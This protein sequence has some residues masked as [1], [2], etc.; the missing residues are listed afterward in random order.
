MGE[1]GRGWAVAVCSFKPP[2]EANAYHSH[3]SVSVYRGCAL[4]FIHSFTALVFLCAYTHFVC[5]CLY[6]CMLGY[7]SLC[8][9]ICVLQTS[10]YIKD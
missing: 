2:F 5:V 3:L 4:L 7:V 10:S 6:L 9:S 1:G 8:T